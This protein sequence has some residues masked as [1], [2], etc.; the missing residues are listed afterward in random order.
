MPK[1]RKNGGKSSSSNR[2]P[3]HSSNSSSG[4][5]SFHYYSSAGDGN[6]VNRE[7]FKM[8]EAYM[9]S[10]LKKMSPFSPDSS[11]E[12]DSSGER[13][14][15]NCGRVH[16]RSGKREMK[17]RDASDESMEKLYKDNDLIKREAWEEME[18]ELGNELFVETFQHCNMIPV[19]QVSAS[20]RPGSDASKHAKS[21]LEG[22]NVHAPQPSKEMIQSM[23]SKCSC[24]NPPIS[25]FKKYREMA[26]SVLQVIENRFE[27]IIEDMDLDW[28]DDTCLSNVF[29]NP[30]E[31]EDEVFC[32]DGQYDD[33]EDEWQNNGIPLGRIKIGDWSPDICYSNQ[34]RMRYDPIT[35]KLYFYAF[36]HPSEYLNSQNINKASNNLKSAKLVLRQCFNRFKTSRVMRWDVDISSLSGL[37]FSQCEDANEM[38]LLVLELSK[39]PVFWT[40]RIQ[41]SSCIRNNW[42]VR[43]DFTA[44][45]QIAKNSRYYIMASDHHLKFLMAVLLEKHGDSFSSLVQKGIPNLKTENPVLS[46]LSIHKFTVPQLS[47]QFLKEHNLFN[48]EVKEYHDKNEFKSH[49]PSYMQDE[50]FIQYASQYSSFRFTA[51]MEK[52]PELDEK[53]EGEVVISPL[54]WFLKSTEKERKESYYSFCTEQLEKK[55][56]SF[57]CTQCEMCDYIKTATSTWECSVCKSHVEDTEKNCSGCGAAKGQKLSNPKKKLEVYVQDEGDNKTIVPKEIDYDSETDIPMWPSNEK[58]MR[59]LKKGEIITR[60]MRKSYAFLQKKAFDDDD[61][62]EDEY[63]DEDEEDE[64]E[65]EE[66]EDDDEV[67]EIATDFAN[68]VERAYSQVS[69]DGELKDF[70]T[71]S[72]VLMKH[73]FMQYLMHKKGYSNS[74][75]GLFQEIQ[76]MPMF[77]ARQSLKK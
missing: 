70:S 48:G 62:D 67:D 28:D 73:M 52:A 37:V 15:C 41:S 58:S 54:D 49:L 60:E 45:Q 43:T 11:D 5:Q 36:L 65:D 75:E 69:K 66:E 34:I 72:D 2:N 23:I 18:E 9:S 10:F 4:N 31:E 46:P 8:M 14:V 63:D 3:T 38:S 53:K 61:E 29:W 25:L 24:L 47:I 1:G 42:R 76:H 57:H 59:Q 13:V 50:C 33:E 32:F 27:N 17:Y 21:K 40:R 16:K 12:S 68:F 77:G 22:K 71:M 64:E 19:V 6:E 35:S 7:K 30:N 20:K 44:G 74:E 56:K 55:S 51:G 39:S 26:K